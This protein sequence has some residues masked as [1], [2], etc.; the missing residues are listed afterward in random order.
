MKENSAKRIKI[1]NLQ[2]QKEIQEIE[3]KFKIELAQNQQKMIQIIS[4]FQ[5]KVNNANLNF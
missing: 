4:S 1:M 2:N 5:N 3:D